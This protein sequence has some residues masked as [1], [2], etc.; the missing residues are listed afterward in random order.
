MMEYWQT[1]LIYWLVIHFL[2]EYTVYPSREEKLYSRKKLLWIQ[3]AIYSVAMLP[4]MLFVIGSWWKSLLAWG[5]LLGVHSIL[6]CLRYFFEGKNL[7]PK[8]A[9]WLAGIHQIMMVGTLLF[10]CYAL[11]NIW[12][13]FR[14]W[15]WLVNGQAVALL[16]LMIVLIWDVASSFIRR[17]FS[18]VTMPSEVTAQDRYAIFASARSGELIGKL[19][20]VVVVLLILFDQFA[21]IGFVLTAKSIARFKML[22]DRDFAERYLIG[23][24]AS[25]IYAIIAGF[26]GKYLMQKMN[27]A[28]F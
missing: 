26:I 10:V 6:V 5:L 16:V 8:M 1:V 17:L 11:L 27:I 23:T 14:H 19:E 9:Y 22:E 28:Y 25:F 12:G 18:L 2:I 7:K 24:L 4:C 15:R 3:M 21:A 13:P 20:R